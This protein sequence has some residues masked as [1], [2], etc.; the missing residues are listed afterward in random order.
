[1]RSFL[2]WSLAAIAF[3][4]VSSVTLNA[5]AA[6]RANVTVALVDTLP[7]AT[8]KAVVVRQADGSTL[9]ALDRRHATPELLG[10][11]LAV[12]K[13]LRQRPLAAGQQQVVPIQGSA[14]GRTMTPAR[15]RFLQTQLRSLTARPH[16]ALRG[17]GHGRFLTVND[18]AL[19]D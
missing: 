17:L 3:A 8:A 11:G 9:L 18:P 4:L 10:A 19:R 12:V 2:T 6:R 1:M 5:Q 15:T 7:I 16:G 14:T 13:H